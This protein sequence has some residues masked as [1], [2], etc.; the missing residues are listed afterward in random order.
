[1]KELFMTTNLTRY[2]SDLQ[3]LLQLG[4]SMQDDAMF[5]NNSKTREHTKEEKSEAKKV[6]GKFRREY[7]K[8]YTEASAVIRQITPD[9]QSEFEYLY[10][11][12]GKRRK[13][14]ITNFNIQDWLGGMQFTSNSV[15]GFNA[16]VMRFFMQ[17]DILKAAERRFESALFDIKQVVQAELFDSELDAASELVKRGFLRGAGAIAGVVLEK[18][19]AQVRRTTTLPS[20]NSILQLATSMTL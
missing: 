8:W 1:M 4:N 9:R 6:R 5:E 12:D 17:L 7:Q 19:L 10:K 15:D 18:H 13:I 14:D 3:A 20:E 2:R 11:G 16:A